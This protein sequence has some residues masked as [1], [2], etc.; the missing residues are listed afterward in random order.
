MSSGQVAQSFILP[1]SILLEHD[2]TFS[3]FKGVS[4][5]PVEIVDAA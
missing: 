4:T 1:A 5:M 3:L 2:S